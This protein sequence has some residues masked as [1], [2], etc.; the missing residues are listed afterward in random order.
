MWPEINKFLTDGDHHEETTMSQ[1][2][3]LAML[4]GI[5]E[6]TPFTCPL[7][8]NHLMAPSKSLLSERDRVAKGDLERI[9]S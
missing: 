7:Y 8:A 9:L 5:A 3:N 1:Q 6:S 2:T 4:D